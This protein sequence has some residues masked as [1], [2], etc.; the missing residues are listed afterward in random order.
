MLHLLMNASLL[1]LLVKYL[2]VL[3]DRCSA[4][5]GVGLQVMEVII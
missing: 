4:N 3:L 2:D 5:V 1:L